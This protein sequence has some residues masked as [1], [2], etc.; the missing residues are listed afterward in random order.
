MAQTNVQAF[1]GD[2]EI[3]SNLAVSGNLNAT[4]SLAQGGQK[5]YPE[6]R[7]E[8]DLS[9]G[10]S[11]SN[12][13][14][15]YLE[16]E[17]YDANIGPFM[18]PVS[19]RVVGDSLSGADS[20]NEET[21]V[22]YARGGGAS[23]HVG[24]CKV[25]SRR[26]D[27]GEFRCLGIWEGTSNAIGIV[28]YL[29]GGYRYSLIT[30]ATDVVV[31]KSSYSKDNS[32][33]AVKNASK[34]DVVG[35]S[36][37]IGELQDVSAFVQVGEVSSFTGSLI[38]PDSTAR[39]GI[40]KTNPGSA[41]DVVGTVTATNGTFS[42]T[43]PVIACTGSDPGDIISKRYSSANRYGMGQ[44]SDGV[45]RLF[46][47][48]THAPASI[49]LSGATNDVQTAG[50]GFNDYM[51]VKINGNVGIGTTNPG[52]L[53]DLK[54]DSINGATMQ[55]ESSG[56]YKTSI[57]QKSSSTADR[58]FQFTSNGPYAGTNPVYNFLALNSA[59]NAYNNILTMTGAG[60][61][62][63][64]TT[65]P[66]STLEVRGII[67]ASY[68]NTDHGMFINNGGTI[69]R[70][71]GGS[72]AGLHFTGNTIWPTNYGGYYNNGGITWG[73]ASYR[74]GQIFSTNSSNS[75]SDRNLKQDINDITESERKV[76]GK[77]TDL[78]KTFRFKDAVSKKGDDARLHNGVIAQ[79]LI[80]AFQSEGL[81][82]H[83][84]GLFCYDEIW[85][86]DGEDELMETVYEKNGKADYTNKDGEVVK[87]SV[88]DEDVN[89]VKKRLGVF[90][91]KDTLGAVFHSGTYSIRYEELLC[92]VVAG[93]IQNE[94]IKYTALEARILALENA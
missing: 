4:G 69:N 41:L 15:L 26:Y 21:L 60:R 88:D 50:A 51:T 40:G 81:D 93:E 79:D 36:V 7:W 49:R 44:Y 86:V 34:T 17:A 55:F 54:K 47:S 65:N 62:G 39:L 11:T 70:D 29:R 27:A 80:E 38:L 23:D 84:Y 52:A 35:T 20:F 90:A 18:F 3:S 28:I 37:G 53:L 72:G 74:W 25:H 75:T 71:Y 76:A 83:Q 33:W 10:T 87:Y 58:S 48:T 63:I 89:T 22:G 57:G 32:T 5:I 73:S 77:I 91:D 61:V 2:V 94:R 82:V 67:Q 19:F 14:P 56:G 31:N 59:E 16:T 13:Y 78:F 45:T 46:T 12:F 43:G 1:S 85:T 42:G 8:V 66:D 92:F 6:R 9:S 24:M 68:S 64:G 30:D